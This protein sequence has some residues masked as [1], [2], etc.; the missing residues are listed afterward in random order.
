MFEN[1]HSEVVLFE[2]SRLRREFQATELSGSEVTS[3]KTV[4]LSINNRLFLDVNP[5]RR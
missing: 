1:N 3:G 2:A 4:H 5:W